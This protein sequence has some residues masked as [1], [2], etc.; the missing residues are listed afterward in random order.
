MGE[1]ELENWYDLTF[2]TTL[3]ALMICNYLE[4]KTRIN[5]LTKFYKNI[6]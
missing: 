6:H 3:T 2:D 4:H 5:S 1:D